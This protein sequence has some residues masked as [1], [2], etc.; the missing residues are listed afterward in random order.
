MKNRRISE[1]I[2]SKTI[3]NTVAGALVHRW[4][5]GEGLMQTEDVPYHL[6]TPLSTSKKVLETEEKTSKLCLQK[7]II[8]LDDGSLILQYFNILLT[9]S[10]LIL[11]LSLDTRGDKISKK[12]MLSVI[13][14][15]LAQF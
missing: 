7:V 10:L 11:N 13:F 15:S 1:E 6:M 4:A 14:L 8:K 3:D 12:K 2:A 9:L 5:C